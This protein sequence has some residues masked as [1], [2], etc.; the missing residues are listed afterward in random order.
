MIPSEY[1]TMTNLIEK[2]NF[3]ETIHYEIKVDGLLHD[4]IIDRFMDLKIV[5]EKGENHSHTTT[6]LGEF[7]DQA[8]L[9]GVLNYLYELHLT[10][11]AVNKKGRED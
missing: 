11:I 5:V 4:L 7:P 2:N 6:I 3:S 10:I 1:L 8:A 9:T